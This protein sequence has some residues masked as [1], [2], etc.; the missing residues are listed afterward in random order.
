[1]KNED[2][3]AFFQALNT[4]GEFFCDEL[5]EIRQRVYW[6]LFGGVTVQE[7]EYASLR[8]MAEE[9]FH[10]V[11]LPAVL[12]EYVR[13]YRTSRRST[14]QPTDPR[15]RPGTTEQVLALREELVSPEEIRK[16][17][18]SV[19]PDPSEAFAAPLEKD[20]VEERKMRLRQQ[21][22]DLTR[23]DV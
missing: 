1:M 13:A 21:L 14:I 6:Q 4:M 9:T 10:K 8:A 18:A 20:A 7:W 19:W 17:I 11:P 23:E 2:R 12:M 3:K 5:S 22:A 15:M 16:L